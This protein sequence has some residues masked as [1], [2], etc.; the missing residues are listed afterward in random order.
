M[1]ISTPVV[2]TFNH[3]VDGSLELRFVFWRKRLDFIVL[4]FEICVGGGV[5]VTAAAAAAA[6]AA[7]GRGC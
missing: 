4:I 5:V 2:G 3:G 6:A 7:V 1:T